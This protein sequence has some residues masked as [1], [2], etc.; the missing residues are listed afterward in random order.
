ML[1]EQHLLL[2]HI[3]LTDISFKAGHLSILENVGFS[4][5]VLS[6]GMFLEPQLES[7]LQEGGDQVENAT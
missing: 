2:N 6:R 7:L 1:H 3:T 4:A 5:A